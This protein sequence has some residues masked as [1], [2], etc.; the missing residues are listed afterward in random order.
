MKT[1]RVVLLAIEGSGKAVVAE[2]GIGGRE[3]VRSTTA[4]WYRRTR[5]VKGLLSSKPA[6]TITTMTRPN[7][8]WP[9][10]TF[11]D[12]N[13]AFCFTALPDRRHERV[14][15]R[16]D[17]EVFRGCRFRQSQRRVV[18]VTTAPHRSPLLLTRR[19]QIGRGDG[20]RAALYGR[21]HTMILASFAM[22]AACYAA[23]A[24][25]LAS[26]GCRSCSATIQPAR[27][28]N[29]GNAGAPLPCQ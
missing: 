24:V 20:D 14:V 10:V 19:F 12:D 8:G 17:L 15:W 16:S 23:R 4:C 3:R 5:R 2:F 26:E 18:T 22:V 7:C 25:A 28:L 1:W 27:R 21:H 29:H 6:A 9:S 11:Q 13:D